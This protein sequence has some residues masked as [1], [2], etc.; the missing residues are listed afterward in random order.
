MRIFT[1]RFILAVLMML[2]FF[3]VRA[4]SKYCETYED[5]M[6]DRWIEIPTVSCFGS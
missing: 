6:A 3:S 2:M 4:K 1:K 5:F